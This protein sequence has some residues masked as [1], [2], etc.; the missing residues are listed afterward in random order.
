MRSIRRTGRALRYSSQ[1]LSVRVAVGTTVADADP[2]ALMRLLRRAAIIAGTLIVVL[3]VA[4][5]L[6]VRALRRRPRPVPA[7][8]AA[9][10]PARAPRDARPG[11]PLR[12]AFDAYRA[13]A[14]DAS[15]D[16]LRGVLFERAG[17]A[18]GATFADALRALG[19]RDTQLARVMA[20]AERARFG[21]A[22]ERAAAARD[23]L[24][25]L[26]AY[27]PQNGAGRVTTPHE[28]RDALA[29]TIIGQPEVVDAL[30]MGLLADG[31]VLLEGMPGVAKT[32]ACRALAA[33]VGGRF[34]RVQFT[35]DLLAERYRRHAHLRSAQR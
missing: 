15:L 26:D 5:G 11:D 9:A 12:A 23:L 35:P 10:P 8:P 2:N 32:L 3:A 31:H 22:H 4:L 20:V 34:K 14:D 33:A 29:R 24:A 1:P 25:L 30:V 21:P 13:R 19:S 7:A 6:L 18:P 28:V 16:A 27:L 17:A